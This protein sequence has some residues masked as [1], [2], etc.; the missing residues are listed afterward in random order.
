MLQKTAHVLYFTQTTIRERNVGTL[1]AVVGQM[2]PQVPQINVGRRNVFSRQ[3]YGPNIEWWG[4][5]RG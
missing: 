2:F 4:M 3:A 5:G 1:S